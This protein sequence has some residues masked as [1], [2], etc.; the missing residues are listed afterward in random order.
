MRLSA[1][2]VTNYRSV[3]DSTEFEVELDKTI[4]VGANEAGKTAV[5]RSLQQVNPPP[6]QNAGLDALRD[7][8]RS[9]YTELDRGDRDVGDVPI[10]QATF[11]LDDDDIAVLHEIDAEVFA[12]AKTLVL[13]R[14]LDNSRNWSL[15]GVS[16]TAQWKDVSKDAA[17]LK[18]HVKGRGRK[19]SRRP[20]NSISYWR[21]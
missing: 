6:G 3:I 17:R 8:P 10:A 19:A 9:R 15:P 4:V 16:R 14:Y 11:T 5:L 20:T 18:A 13:T 7:Y 21:P 2:Q 1:A 12:D